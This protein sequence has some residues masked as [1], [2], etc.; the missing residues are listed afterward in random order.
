MSEPLI[1]PLPLYPNFLSKADAIASEI[2]LP[3]NVV[4]GA[5]V[6]LW[7]YAELIGGGGATTD[8]GP[9][10]PDT[11]AEELAAVSKLFSGDAAALLD[12]MQQR[13]WLRFRDGGVEFPRLKKLAGTVIEANQEVKASQIDAWFAEFWAAYRPSDGAAK[14][15]RNDARKAFGNIRG[16]KLDLVKVIVTAAAAHSAAGWPTFYGKSPHARRWLYN[17]MWEDEVPV[18]TGTTGTILETAKD[19]ARTGDRPG[20]T[21]ELSALEKAR[22]RAKESRQ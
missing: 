10:V 2:K 12:S 21:R 13:D 3:G 1:H 7:L 14:G 18:T 17:R 4:I 5:L 22:L 9:F 8:S 11:D 6:R 16:L 20:V 15:P 19:G